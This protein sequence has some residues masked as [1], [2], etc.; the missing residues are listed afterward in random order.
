MLVGE[1]NALRL[2]GSRSPAMLSDGRPVVGT[3]IASKDFQVSLMYFFSTAWSPPPPPA[4]AS[5]GGAATSTDV[6]ARVATAATSSRIVLRRTRMGDSSEMA[7]VMDGY[8]MPVM[9]T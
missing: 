8:L 3:A 4:F 9:A 2:A 5:M 1:V 6:V 7:R